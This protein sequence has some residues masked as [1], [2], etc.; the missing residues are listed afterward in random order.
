M[1]SV[2][3]GFGLTCAVML[4]SGMA[5][6]KG[7]PVRGEEIYKTKCL[8]CHPAS[9]DE[10]PEPGKPKKIGPHLLGIYG[11][12]AGEMKG[13]SFSMMLKIKKFVWD[14]EKLEQYLKNP[15]AMIPGGRMVLGS[16]PVAQDRDDV[17]AYIKIHLRADSATAAAPAPA[18]ATAAAPAPAP[19]PAPTAAPAQVAT[20]ALAA[21]PVPAQVATSTP[22]PTA[23]PAQIAT[24]TP[25][26]V[27]TPALAATPV[28]ALC[29]S[30]AL[31]DL[32]GDGDLDA[33]VAITSKGHRVWLN[34]GSGNFTEAASTA[35]AFK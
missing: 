13:Y 32:D 23:A 20:S 6:A 1:K 16:M 14:D 30:V 8:Q 4:F 35:A 2:L 5:L 27:A 21:T 11:R 24:P 25:A 22:A 28:P 18:A 34:D 29:S 33:F 9:P 12:P 26:Q 17:I 15:N 3:L 19:A 31:G 10:K 7:D